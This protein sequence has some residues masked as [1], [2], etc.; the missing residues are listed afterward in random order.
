MTNMKL[1]DCRLNVKPTLMIENLLENVPLLYAVS[2]GHE[3]ILKLLIENGA[4]IDFKALD[5]AT[6]LTYAVNYKQKEMAQFLNENVTN[7]NSTCNNLKTPLYLALVLNY[8][9]FVLL[10]WC[11]FNAKDRDKINPIEEGLMSK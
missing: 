2:Y 9:E 10:K 1:S 4:S 8:E 5:G 7:T 6:A 3:R 11:F